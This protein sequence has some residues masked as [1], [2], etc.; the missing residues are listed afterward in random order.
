MEDTPDTVC[1]SNL[2]GLMRAC[3]S[4]LRADACDTARKSAMETTYW[5]NGSS[6]ASATAHVKEKHLQKA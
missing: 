2:K 5:K 6:D 3:I 4:K 1:I